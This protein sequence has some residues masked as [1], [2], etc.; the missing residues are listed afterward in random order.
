MLG[1]VDYLSSGEKCRGFATRSASGTRDRGIELSELDFEL[2]RRARDRG[3]TPEFDPLIAKECIAADVI[4]MLLGIDDAECVGGA[5][6]GC[7]AEDRW[8]ERAL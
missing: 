7:V 6:S 4:E 2:R 8:A 1:R 3:V 5:D